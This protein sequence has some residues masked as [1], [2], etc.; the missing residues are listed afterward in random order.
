MNAFGPLQRVY[1]RPPSPE[2]LTAWREYGWHGEPDAQAAADEHAAFRAVLEEAGAE[3]VVGTT[4]VHG[5]PDAIY[6]YDPVLI[7]DAGA[8][9]LRPAKAGRREEPVAVATDLEAARV[10]VLAAVEPPATAEGGD[11]V[12]LDRSTLLVGLGYRTNRAGADALATILTPAGV[13]V[14]AFD[15]PHLHGPTRCL[16]LLSL[17]SPLDTDLVVAYPAL[18]PVRIHQLLGERDIRMVEVPEEEFPT[19]GPNVLALAPRVALALEG[20]PGT[21]RCLEDAGVQVRTYRGEQISRLG[22]GGPT[23]LT[24][25]LA[26]G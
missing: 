6:A 14:L 24:L 7:T 8:V 25:P 19:M 5:D 4:P 18:L 1:V 23:C 21:R 3:V 9:L 22:D 11:L 17:I 26:R 12:F 13:E 15:L 10:P 2:A 20:N 16:H